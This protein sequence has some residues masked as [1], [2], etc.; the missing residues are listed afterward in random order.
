MALADDTVEVC[1]NHSPDFHLLW[2]VW[3]LDKSIYLVETSLDLLS[4]KLG[5]IS[6][7]DRSIITIHSGL[8]IF[9]V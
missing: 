4:P 7:T 1:L 6:M 2:N 8:A 9:A 3:V 5:L